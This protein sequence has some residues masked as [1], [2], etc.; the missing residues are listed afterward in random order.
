MIQNIGTKKYYASAGANNIV[1]KVP[2][3]LHRIIVGK[4]VTSGVI[5]VSDHASDGD[6]NVQIELGGDTMQGVYEIG[7]HF[8]VGITADLTNQTD[9]T[10]VY[11]PERV[12]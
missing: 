10:F 4:D 8:D 2:A 7:T 3:I 5:E 9:V 1:C 11:T 6:G 12:G